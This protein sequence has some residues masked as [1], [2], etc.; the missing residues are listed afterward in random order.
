MHFFITTNMTIKR[1]DTK[2]YQENGCGLNSLSWLIP[3]ND[4]W[5][6]VIGRRFW[7]SLRKKKT[8]RMWMVKPLPASRQTNPILLLSKTLSI[9]GL[10]II[11]MMYICIYLLVHWQK[12]DCIWTVYTIYPI[13]MSRYQCIDSN[14]RVRSGPKLRP[15]PRERKTV[16]I[17]AE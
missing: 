3:L 13:Y 6:L 11:Y 16:E 4:Q 1:K 8:P 17:A 7:S 14:I 15:S 2:I 10:Y 12:M 9:Y 5:P